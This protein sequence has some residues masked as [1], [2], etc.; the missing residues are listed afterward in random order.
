MFKALQLVKGERLLVRGGMT[1]VGLAAAAIAKGFGCY[2]AATTRNRDRETLLKENGADEVIIDDGAIA[3]R[4]AEKF[5]KVL[6]LVGT[7]TLE[8]LL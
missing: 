1:S 4:L 3:K 2:V 6:E 7:I 8:D 5:D